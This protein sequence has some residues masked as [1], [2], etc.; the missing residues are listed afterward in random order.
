MRM[1]LQLR[2]LLGF[3]V[4][5]LAVPAAGYLW[6]RTSLPLTA[7]QVTLPGL[8]AAARIT[9]DSHG[10]PTIVAASEHDAAF[11]LGFL[12]AQDRLFSMD[13]MRRYGAGR[14]SEWFG[15]RTVPIDRTMRTLGIY[16]AAER[17]L[18]TLS[19]ETRM[20]F[21]AYA[22]GVNAFLATR[23]GALPPEYY[24]LRISPEPWRPADSLVWAK[25]MDLQLTGNYRGELLR[26]RMLQHL[27][28]A[29]LAILYPPYREDAPVTLEEMHSMLKRLPL[30]DVAA[31]LPPTAGPQPAS[32]NWVLSGTRTAS[33]KPLLANDTHLDYS[34][35]GVW[36]LV[37][38]EIPGLTLIGVTAPGT[39][40]IIIG[41]NDRIAWGFTTTGADVEDV[42]IE[43]P[44]PADPARYL[45]PG[46]ALPFTT[47]QETILVRDGAPVSLTVRS[48][49]H[50]PVISD[51]AAA[52]SGDVLALQATWLSDDDRSPDAIPEMVRARN[53]SEFKA[54]LENWAAPMQN[55]V[56]ADIDG[57]IG[58]IAPSRVPIRGKGDGWLPAPGWTGEYDWTGYIP[59]DALPSA[60]NPPSGRIVSANNKI[61]PDSYPYL[62]TRDWELPERAE[63]IIEL[64]DRAPRQS[65]D[66][67]AA[68][69][70]DDVSLSARRLLPLMLGLTPSA[71]GRAPALQRLAAWDGRMDRDR[72]EPLI[73]VAWLREL[74]RGLLAD[75]LG[76]D[77]DAYW[78]L[79]PD[80]VEL[81]LSQHQ[82]WCAGGTPRS[83][84]CADALAA[85]LDRALD[86][87]RRRYGADMAGWR[88]G[89]AHPAVFESAL[90]SHVPIIGAWLDLSIPV[91]G[92]NDTVNAGAMAIRDPLRP[93]IARHGP[94]LR[95][96]IDLADPAA[97]RFMITPGQSGNPLSRHWGDL[98]RPWRDGAYLG[99][100]DDSSGGVLALSPP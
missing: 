55:I 43:K 23:R 11:A 1:K 74:L 17:Q 25:L 4:I 31:M 21:D 92:S 78:S 54:A 24:L 85:A 44:D 75:K 60:Y 73:F 72:G 7:G 95:M 15:E 40:F 93:F 67:T 42:F 9:R 100:S 38:E 20:V 51:L 91:D 27:T 88:W 90:W 2:L 8:A 81:V 10:I 99:F 96:I 28:P 5:V 26:A 56:Y 3:G 22:A 66:S 41:H 97:A 35:P 36:Y 37:R 61:V 57:N 87:L 30:D 14:L 63:R 49:R 46:G 34:A 6:L 69:Q 58:F 83:E 32:N 71:P 12:H 80:L 98:M 33:G 29:Q 64:V 70:A 16:R 86:E 47:R 76:V 45:A 77:F 19:P 68:I 13:A 84:T 53:W 62:L 79:R 48:T 50:G 59:F 89:A 18:A 52:S 82:D 65:P 94:T 39:P